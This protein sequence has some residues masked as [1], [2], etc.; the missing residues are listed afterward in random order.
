GWKGGS[1]YTGIGVTYNDKAAANLP[2]GA[3]YTSFEGQTVNA[4]DVLVKYTWF[5]D[6]DLD[7]KVTS[8][9]Y[10]Q[11]DTGFLAGRTGWIN[12][13]FDYNGV[14]NSNDYFLI[15]S[16]FLAQ[17]STVLVPV[18]SAASVPLSGVTAVPEPA[19]FGVLAAAGAGLLVRRRRHG[20]R[21]GAAVA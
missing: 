3:L 21:V 17:G 13:D 2:P 8:N 16:A 9:D 10:F 7:G 18:A 15:D 20:R 11:I 14:I 4:N 5:G 12:G 6:A 19:T 1:N